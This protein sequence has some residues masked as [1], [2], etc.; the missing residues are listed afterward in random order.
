MQKALFSMTLLGACA[1]MWTA[2]PSAP[3]YGQAGKAAV[4]FTKEHVRIL[5][6]PERICVEGTYWF[7][8]HDASP[9]RQKLFYPFPID[10]MHSRPE[11]IVVW[12]GEDAVPFR[13]MEDGVRFMVEVPAKSSAPVVVYYEQPCRDG[14][15][16][17]ILRSTVM[18][19]APLEHASFEIQVPDTLALDWVSY[20]IDRVRKEGSTEIHEF[21]RDRFMPDKDLCL[22]WRVRPHDDKPQ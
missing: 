1:T 17:Y 10:S 20:D 8:N 14:S 13:Q 3:A 21:S 4:T 12:L 6:G 2:L 16:C 18:W 19:D 11:G 15:G 9:A 5:V 22:R 7:T